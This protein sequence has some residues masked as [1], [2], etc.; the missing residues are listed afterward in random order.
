MVVSPTLTTTITD[1]P[2]PVT[3]GNDVQYTLTV[4]NNGIAPVAN[5]HVVDTLPPGR[6]S[7]RRPANCSGTGP[8]DCSLGALA[9]GASA[10]VQLVVTSPATVPERRHDDELRGR[11]AGQ[12]HRR[13]ARSPR[14]RRPTD[15]VAKGFVEPGRLAHDP[16]RRPG[17]AEPA[18]HR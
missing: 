11:D 12:Q 6:R 3:A 2:D 5:A 15:G 13:R 8:V 4:T 18:E 14:S 16:G 7:A 17:D 9:V 1:S 10:E